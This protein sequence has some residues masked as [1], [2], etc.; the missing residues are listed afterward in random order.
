MFVSSNY[1]SLFMLGIVKRKKM[2]KNNNI[3]KNSKLRK[4][5]GKME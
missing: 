2:V 4:I 3:N 5:S 1:H